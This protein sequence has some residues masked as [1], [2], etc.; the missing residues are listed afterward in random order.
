MQ[1]FVDAEEV[2]AGCQASINEANRTI[3][4]ILAHTP[5][6]RD[7][8]AERLA[9]AYSRRQEAEDTILRVAAMEGASSW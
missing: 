9:W 6:Y 3:D 8:S 2:I 4:E 5:E 1:K 7:M